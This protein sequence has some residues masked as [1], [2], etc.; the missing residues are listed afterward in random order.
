MGTR[1]QE[2][3]FL[4]QP[5][6]AELHIHSVGGKELTVKKHMPVTIEDLSILGMGLLGKIQLPTDG[7]QPILYQ[8]K[9][10][11]NAKLIEAFGEIQ[12]TEDKRKSP[13]HPPKYFYGFELVFPTQQSF[14]AFYQFFNAYCIQKRIKYLNTQVD[15]W[16]EWE[17]GKKVKAVAN[18][19]KKEE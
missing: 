19:W 2:R 15:N 17:R 6:Q 14:A 16:N 4:T 12:W 9:F 3:I 1:K 5:I 10:R 11:Y 13:N 8:I 18:P 7:N